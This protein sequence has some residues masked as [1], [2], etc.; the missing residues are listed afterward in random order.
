MVNVLDRANETPAICFEKLLSSSLLPAVIVSAAVL[1]LRRVKFKLASKASI[2]VLLVCAED[3][4]LPS[5]EMVASVASI[6]DVTC[7]LMGSISALTKASTI[8]GI[9]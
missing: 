7:V 9:L 4:K 8:T 3:F 6:L 1:E 2:T 5:P